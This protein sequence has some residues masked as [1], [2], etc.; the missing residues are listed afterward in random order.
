MR[1]SSSVLILGISLVA[2]P[3]ALNAWQAAAPAASQPGPEPHLSNVR[4][5]TFD[6]ENAEA[7]FSFD[8]RQADLPVDARRRG[9]RPDLHDERRRLPPSRG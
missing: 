9:L 3:Y 2:A 1:I 7:Y 4:Q 5:L 6:G 8:G